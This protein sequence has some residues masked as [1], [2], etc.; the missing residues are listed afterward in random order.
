[1]YLFIQAMCACVYAYMHTDVKCARGY[2]SGEVT[3]ISPSVRAGTSE[4]GWP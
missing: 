1:M 3:A 4:P 2:A